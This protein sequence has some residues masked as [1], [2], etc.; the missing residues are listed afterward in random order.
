MH[1]LSKRLEASPRVVVPELSC[2]NRKAAEIAEAEMAR[3]ESLCT[4]V[5]D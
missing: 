5:L 4:A 1:K 2:E 3:R